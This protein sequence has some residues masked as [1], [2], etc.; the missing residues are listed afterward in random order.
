MGNCHALSKSHPTTPIL[1]LDIGGGTTNLAL[2][3]DGQ[4][5]AT[6]CLFVGARHFEFAPG[7]YT[8]KRLSPYATALLEHLKIGSRLGDTLDAGRGRIDTRLSGPS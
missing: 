3:L 4:V 5:L 8:L 2:G 1:N 7:G 6:G